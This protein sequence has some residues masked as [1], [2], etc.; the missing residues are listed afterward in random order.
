VYKRQAF[1][2]K[3]PNYNYKVENR[4][5]NIGDIIC[6]SLDEQNEAIN[7][8]LV[9]RFTKDGLPI[10]RYLKDNE[11]MEFEYLVRPYYKICNTLINK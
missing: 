3:L 11:S 7:E 10:G 5:L 2:Y 4:E 6:E 9:T 1:G 8:F